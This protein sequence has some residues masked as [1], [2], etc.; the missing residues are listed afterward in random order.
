MAFTDAVFDGQAVLVGITTVR[1]DD[2]ATVAGLLAA[3]R[4][5]PVMV[6]NIDAFPDLIRPDILVDACMRKRAQP[7]DQ[8]DN[9]LGSLVTESTE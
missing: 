4:V 8:H 9:V 6:T 7:V 2:P 5:L 1:I 3:H